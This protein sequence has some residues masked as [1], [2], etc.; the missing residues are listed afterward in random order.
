M[1]VF[2]KF[3]LTSKTQFPSPIK[4]LACKIAVRLTSTVKNIKRNFVQLFVFCFVALESSS[5]FNS[6]LALP[7]REAEFVSVLF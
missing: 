6:L 3:N 2:L 5:F 4:W 7:N 1:F